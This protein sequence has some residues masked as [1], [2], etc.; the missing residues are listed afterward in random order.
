LN[1]DATDRNK[2]VERNRSEEVSRKRM[3]SNLGHFKIPRESGSALW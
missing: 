1:G 2:E 3:N